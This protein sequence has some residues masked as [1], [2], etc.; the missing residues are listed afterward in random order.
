MSGKLWA[1]VPEYRLARIEATLFRDMRFGW[2][3][4]GHLD[5]GGHFFVEQTRTTPERW[6]VTY[7]N[8]QFNGK[9]LLFKT[10]SMHEVDKISDFRRIPDN[11]TLAQGI[12]ML[13][14][15]DKQMAANHD[16]Q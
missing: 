6:D 2:G 12:E 10:I 15:N 16:Q 4:L 5:K 8:I 7:Q 14:K 1:A 11:L 3:I 9:V 13:N